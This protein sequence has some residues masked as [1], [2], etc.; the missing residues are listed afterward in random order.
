MIVPT[1]YVIQKFFEIG[2][3]PKYNKYNNTYQCSCPIC[4]EGT[5]LG[6]KRRCYYIPEKNNIYC[7]NCGWSS[8]PLKWICEATGV[9]PSDIYKELQERVV[10]VD[11]ILPQPDLKPRNTKSL[12]DDCI[13]LFDQTQ[14]DY[15][16]DNSVLHVCLGL[17][18]DRR[19]TTAVNKPTCLYLSLKDKVHK[20]RLI[21]PFFNEQ[22]EI[23]FYQSRTILSADSHK[24]PKYIS[25]VNGDKTLFNI[26]KVDTNKEF[27]YIFEG[28]INAC[29]V[30]NGVAVAGINKGPVSFTPRQQE[31]LD[32]ILKTQTKIWVLDSQWIDKTSLEKT[33]VLLDQG[34]RVF[35]WPEVIGKRFKDFND[36][37]VYGKKDEIKEEFIQKNTY[38]GAAGI[39]K[40]SEIVRTLS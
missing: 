31:Q 36:I 22:G 32:T 23:E 28:P 33:R 38:V 6:K 26:D 19:L 7:H 35:I 11:S 24:K 10:D 9:T 29:F 16:R 18:N 30:V 21:I 37:A 25:K 34:H 39:L 2:Y 27:V 40:L 14:L 15:Y 5:S 1:D 8:Q 4:K 20:N 12:P 3:Y 13:N 17:L